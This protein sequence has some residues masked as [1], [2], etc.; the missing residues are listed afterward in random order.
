MSVYTKLNSIIGVC[1]MSLQSEISTHDGG[2]VV[3]Y[4]QMTQ[5]LT[6][7]VVSQDVLL[8]RIC[9]NRDVS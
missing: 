2:H 8:Q 7:T 3:E 4:A 6:M 5:L 9:E 1:E